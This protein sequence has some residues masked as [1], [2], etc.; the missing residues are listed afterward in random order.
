MGPIFIVT[1]LNSDKDLR[2]KIEL[3]LPPP[4]K[5]VAT[6]P[7]E[8][9]VA[10]YTVLHVLEIDYFSTLTVLYYYSYNST[11]PDANATE[12]TCTHCRPCRFLAAV[13][14]RFLCNNFLFWYI[15]NV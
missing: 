4:I 13:S 14:G 7:C 11:K 8:K 2:S 15:G 12:Q 10:N 5:S 9:K 1:L 3:K 6:L